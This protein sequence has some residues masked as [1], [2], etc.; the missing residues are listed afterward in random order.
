M[1]ADS[2]SSDSELKLD[3]WL[4]VVHTESQKESIAV[5]NPETVKGGMMSKSFVSYTLQLNLASD[6]AGIVTGSTTVEARRRFSDFEA[7]R[8]I[9]KELYIGMYLPPLTSK[10]RHKIENTDSFIARRQRGLQLFC[11]SIMRNPFTRHDSTWIA[12]LNPRVKTITLEM[13]QEQSQSAEINVGLMRWCQLVEST[14]S[15]EDEVMVKNRCKDIQREA[16]LLENV[17]REHARI[18]KELRKLYTAQVEAYA[19]LTEAAVEWRK[20]EATVA[21]LAG[22]SPLSTNLPAGL[23]RHTCPPEQKIPNLLQLQSGLSEGWCKATAQL[24]PVCQ[25]L[26]GDCYEFM[27]NL[28]SSVSG[29]IKI[30][31][32]LVLKCSD[33]LQKT[34]SIQSKKTSKSQIDE[35]AAAQTKL[36]DYKTKL[37]IYTKM[38][39]CYSLPMVIEERELI[40][41]QIGGWTATSMLRTGTTLRNLG[42]TFFQR[43]EVSILSGVDKSSILDSMQRSLRALGEREFGVYE[44]MSVPVVV[45]GKDENPFQNLSAENSDNHSGAQNFFESDTE[46][47]TINS[48][49]FEGEHQGQVSVTGNAVEG[50]QADGDVFL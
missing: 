14:P 15:I 33:A 23:V 18:A 45:K 22:T 37:S 44:N 3:Q 38:F 12:F 25:H 26:Q 5:L 47:A 10:D 39:F 34:L 43:T 27:A 7:L 17:T 35:L 21:E 29:M 11:D 48:G 24:P 6:H 8:K 19:K 4:S 41:A 46:E 20:V 36:D 42:E 31:E 16:I 13:A 40:V 9:L 28:A 50:R 30:R 1:M 32:K 49:I 2:D